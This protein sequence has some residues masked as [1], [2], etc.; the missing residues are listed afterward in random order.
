MQK[1]YKNELLVIHVHTNIP[2]AESTNHGTACQRNQSAL[3]TRLPSKQLTKH[4]MSRFHQDRSSTHT[5]TQPVSPN[6]FTN[7]FAHLYDTLYIT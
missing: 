1:R 6:M 2:P 4:S 5:R 7:R 3:R